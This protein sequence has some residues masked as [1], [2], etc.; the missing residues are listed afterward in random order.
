MA[1]FIYKLVFPNT[2]K[3]Y[4]GFSYNPES[5]LQRHR[6]TLR[7]G[8]HHSKKLQAEYPECG[9]PTMEIL[10]ECLTED[11]PRREIFWIEHYDSY[12]NGY[13]SALGG[14]GTG[15]GEACPSSKY[16]LDDYMAVLAFLAHTDMTTK[17]ISKELDVG[18]S[19]VL[20]IS[21]QINHLYLKDIM[22]EEWNLMISKK[23]HHPNWRSYPPVRSPQGVIH[24]VTNARAFARE[25]G[26]HQSQLQRLLAGKAKKISGGWTL[27]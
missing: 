8:I 16:T 24:E 15:Y 26:L 11:A 6:Q 20:N 7:D 17:E 18:I 14:T 25:H 22:P 3:V 4:V 2:S 9:I 1:T 23:R 27:C 13:N 12:R 10:E 19:T 5:R 21:S